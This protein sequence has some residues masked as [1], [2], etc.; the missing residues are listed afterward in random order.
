ML[1]LSRTVQNFHDVLSVLHARKSSLSSAK[2]KPTL[3]KLVFGVIFTTDSNYLITA[4]I[5][6]V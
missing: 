3:A 5:N 4:S 1:E 6:H 2:H